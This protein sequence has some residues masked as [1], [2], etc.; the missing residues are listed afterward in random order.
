M[1]R[2]KRLIWQLFPPF[3]LITLFSLLA[4]S[5]YASNSLH[6]FFLDQTEAD[7]K[8]RALLVEK[9]IIALLAPLDAAEVD[10]IC[11]D[12]GKKSATRITV[13]LPSGQVVGD[14]R[15][16]P[17][18]MDN[19]AGRP[20]IAL[21]LKGNPGQSIRYSNTL[22]QQMMYV[23][24]PLQKN[25]TILG[26]IR[27]SVPITSIKRQ[28][29]AIQTKIALGGLL[30]AVLAAW[31][32]LLISRRISRPLEEMKKVADR[33]A[34][35]DLSHRLTMTDSEEL[36]S[37]ADALNQMAAQLDRRI[38]TVISQRNELETVLS[39]MMEGVIAVNNEERIIR[40]NE[41]SAGFF[42]CDPEI[43]QGRDLQ[44]VIRNSALQQFVRS[45]LSSRE[46]REDDIIVYLNGE[47]TLNLKS[48]PLLDANKESI[49]TLVVFND[50]TQLRRLENMRRDFVANVS[51]EIKTPLT[52]IK[53][54]VETL[55]RGNVDDP[56]EARRFLGIIQ[57]HADRLSS[58]VEDLLSLSRIEQEDEGKTIK[59]KE[60]DVND[61]FQSAM[62]ICRS[63]AE[64][65]NI[66][67][68][69]VCDEQISAK[70]DTTLLEQ[71]V[72]NLLDNAIK[73]SEPKNTIL[74]KAQRNNSE[75]RISVEDQGIGIA[76]KH[77]P[78]LFER[79]YRVDRARSRNLGGTGLGL[80]IVK[81]IAQA[82]GGRI[83][84]ESTL[85]VGSVFTIHLP[86]K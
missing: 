49:G 16:T 57:K 37:L 25:Q 40:M 66:T 23:A 61:V 84:V 15:E 33:F 18:L 43:C 56:Q 63:K 27:T 60:G 36:A 4:V 73:Y 8:I 11:K 64:E 34:A 6:H 45:A 17:H 32:S 48:S 67:I 2:R 79:F 9:Q 41:A 42:D 51:H 68:R 59:L 26:V 72:V 20:E 83:T 47:S 76:K 71:A 39:S 31:I 75:I 65:K 14:S 3:L 74:L 54:F 77:L 10:A 46:P 19:H 82:H 70:F 55:H 28:L 13:I 50:V 52:A 21:A 30:I 81:H 69:P 12:I 1:N 24:I 62:Q 35:G 29:R 78:R 5:W 38:K 22:R 58:I 86:Q 44:E 53:G 85:G 7:L 80:A